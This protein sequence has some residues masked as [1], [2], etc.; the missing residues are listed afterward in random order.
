MSVNAIHPNLR[1]VVDH[2]MKK[3][4]WKINSAAKG[5]VK[6]CHTFVLLA[7]LFLRNTIKP[8]QLSSIKTILFLTSCFI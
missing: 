6:V 8:S 5:V 4:K 2:V 1:M 7:K 3:K